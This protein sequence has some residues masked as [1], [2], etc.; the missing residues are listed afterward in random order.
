MLFEAFFRIIYVIQED[1]L[2]TSQLFDDIINSF[3]RGEDQ[4]RAKVHQP[5]THLCFLCFTGM[6]YFSVFA[7]DIRTIQ[8]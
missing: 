1:P 4:P 8:G 2:M 7:Q 6:Q 5:N 3:S